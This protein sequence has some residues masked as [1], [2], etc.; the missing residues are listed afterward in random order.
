[1]LNLFRQAIYKKQVCVMLWHSPCLFGCV[2]YI[3]VFKC[4]KLFNIICKL[5]TDV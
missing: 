4:N 3:A 1:M 2:L 5:K